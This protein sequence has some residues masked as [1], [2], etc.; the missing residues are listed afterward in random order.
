MLHGRIKRQGG[1]GMDDDIGARL[2]PIPEWNL[3]IPLTSQAI[4]PELLTGTS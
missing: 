4:Y 1:S 2:A 3:L